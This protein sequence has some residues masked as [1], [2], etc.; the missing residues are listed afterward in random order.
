VTAIEPEPFGNARE[1][2][3]LYDAV[4]DEEILSLL[5][6]ARRGDA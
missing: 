4:S 6:G 2:Y 3:E 5:A 1:W